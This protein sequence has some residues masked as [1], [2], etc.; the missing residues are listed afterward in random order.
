[1]MRSSSN[2]TPGLTSTAGAGVSLIT[3]DRMDIA[4]SP[5]NGRVPVAISYKRTPSEKMSDR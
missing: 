3:A 5:L 2:G 1:M 4:D